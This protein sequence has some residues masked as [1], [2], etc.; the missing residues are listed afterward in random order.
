MSAMKRPS[1]PRYAV[2]GILLALGAPGGW[3]LLLAALGGFEGGSTLSEIRAHSLLYLYLLGSTVIAFGLFGAWAGSLAAKLAASNVRLEQM[4]RT[5]SLTSLKNAGYFQQRLR[6]ECARSERSG[7]PLSLILMDLDTFKSVNDRYGH[8]VGDAALAHVGVQIAACCRLGDL[9]CRV[10]GEEFAVLCPGANLE[11]A[12]KV[13]ERVRT[14]L[15]ENR[16]EAPDGL[17]AVTASL[18]VAVRSDTPA[19]LYEAAD[20]ALYRA[21]AEGRNR[22]AVQHGAPEPTPPIGKS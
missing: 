10:G 14:S 9:A 3:L 7:E 2:I 17:L 15:N 8:A 12:R 20:R 13:A 6:S 22:V 4:A 18:G 16:F 5:D 1:G 19:A 11:E 21:K